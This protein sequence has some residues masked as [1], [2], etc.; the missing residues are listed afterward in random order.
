MKLYK[1][2]IVPRC[3]G[4]S[5]DPSNLIELTYAEHVEAH[6]LLCEG[7]P[8][9]F[10]LRFAYLNMIN[11]PEQAHKEACSRGGKQ[12]KLVGGP[13]KGGRT[14]GKIAGKITGTRNIRHWSAN[15]PEAVAQNAKK[16]GMTTAKIVICV[17][18][19]KEFESVNHAMVAV[20]SS[21]IARAIKTGIRAA[22]FHWKYQ[23]S[24]KHVQT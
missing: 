7:N 10:G 16:A 9:H 15:N 21:N 23:E 1:H 13:A 8:D 22:G 18:T 6:R 14:G 11:L 3:M 19:G 24:A 5:D 2:H 4:G 12:S 17:E 20:K